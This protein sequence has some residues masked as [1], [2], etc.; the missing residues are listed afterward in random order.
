MRMQPIIESIGQ[1]AQYA[2]ALDAIA[3][4]AIKPGEPCDVAAVSVAARRLSEQLAAIQR[5]IAREVATLKGTNQAIAAK[6]DEDVVAMLVRA[7]SA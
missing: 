6:S 3:G 1:A 2:V 7:E 5:Q 4:I